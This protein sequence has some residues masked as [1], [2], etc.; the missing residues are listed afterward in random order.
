[1]PCDFHTLNDRRVTHITFYNW[2]DIL[3]HYAGGAEKYCYEMAWRLVRDGYKVTWVSSRAKN[4][5]K[6]TTFKGINIIRIGNIFTVFILSLFTS[7]KIHKN[8]AVIDSVNAIPFFDNPFAMKVVLIHHFVPFQV[9]KDK[10]GYLAPVAFFF[11]NVFNPFFYRSKKV[12]TVSDSTR[13]DLISYGYKDPMVVMLGTDEFDNSLDRKKKIIV[14]PGPLRP[15]KNHDQ[16]IEAFSSIPDDYKLV[17]FGKPETLKHELYLKQLASDFGLS[18]RIKFLGQ[19]SEEKKFDIYRE[20]KFAVFATDK[21]GWGLSCIEAQ[22]FSCPVV[23]YNVPGIRDSVKQNETGLLVEYLDI[24]GLSNAMLKLIGDNSLYQKL[25]IGA[26]KWAR[27][28]DW[29]AC[30]TDFL[31]KMNLIEKKSDTATKE[32]VPVVSMLK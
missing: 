25:S 30:Y 29:D 21:E 14:A 26:Y 2:R 8:E 31:D 32:P 17:I 12:L 28:M 6:R 15:W 18:D 23:A 7:R 16:I 27:S 11:Q 3:N 20:S 22:G 19:I 10:L 4:Q 9:L 24:K 13:N 1:M 5:S